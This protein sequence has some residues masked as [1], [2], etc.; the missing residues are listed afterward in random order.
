MTRCIVGGKN[1]FNGFIENRQDGGNGM[2][3]VDHAVY[4]LEDKWCVVFWIGAE[5]L[6][7]ADRAIDQA[8]YDAWG[9]A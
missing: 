9:V 5:V 6:S 4:G 7:T 2:S 8:F 3:A 1:V